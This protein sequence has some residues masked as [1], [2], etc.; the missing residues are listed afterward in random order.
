MARMLGPQGE[1][2]F[3][4]G[5]TPGRSHQLPGLIK[6]HIC[7]LLEAEYDIDEAFERYERISL[8]LD[9]RFMLCAWPRLWPELIQRSVIERARSWCG[10]AAEVFPGEILPVSRKLGGISFSALLMMVSM[11]LSSKARQPSMR[12]TAAVGSGYC[13][14]SHL[15]FS[16]SILSDVSKT[17]QK[18]ADA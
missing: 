6:Y 10:G 12:S 5:A 3:L 2:Q 16:A 15:G 17:E 11:M 9:Q 14:L 8:G 13:T 18:S 4:G 7:F 1:R